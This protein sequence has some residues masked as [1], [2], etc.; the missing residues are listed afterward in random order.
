MANKLTDELLDK[1]EKMLE[2]HGI[3]DYTVAIKDPDSP[4]DCVRAA[5]SVWWR[6]GLGI[7][8]IESCKERRRKSWED[9]EDESD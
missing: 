7:E 5:G 4:F 3:N 6:M 9:T 1:I 2:A 8:L